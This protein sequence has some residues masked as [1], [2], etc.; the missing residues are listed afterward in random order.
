MY[1]AG[2]WELK[3]FNGQFLQPTYTGLTRDI[4]G[5]YTGHIWD[6]RWRYK[7]LLYIPYKPHI[8]ETVEPEIYL[9]CDKM[10]VHN[11]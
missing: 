7:S 2:I 3:G 9:F 1:M 6:L 5:T 11:R 10:H 8:G 4:Y